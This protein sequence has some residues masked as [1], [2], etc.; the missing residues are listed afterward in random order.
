MAGKWD[1][2]LKRLV[3]ANPQEF[4][5]WLVEGAVFT[6]ELSVE[7]NREIYIDI[8]YETMR[9]GNRELVHIEFQR[10]EDENMAWRALEYNAF[11]TCKYK[12]PVHSFV[13]YLKKEGK[14]A[15]SPLVV[16]S[17]DGH[18]IWRF[19]FT[20][21]KLWEIPTERFRQM[22][23]AGVLPLL[24]LTREG[25]HREVVEEAI[26]GIEQ[27]EMSRERKDTLLTIVFNLATL[28][29]NKQEDLEWLKG[30]FRMYQDIIKDT[31]IYQIIVQEGIEKQKKKEVDDLHHIILFTVQRNFPAL[32]EWT[33]ERIEAIADLDILKKLVM[34]T[35][36]ADSVDQM[37]ALFEALQKN[38]QGH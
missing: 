17:A 20:N 3:E 6:R 22:Q 18:E 11:A 5:G 38:S 25:G 19:N 30:R 36:S 35:I 24:A 29:F 32:A 37:R 21:I 16:K 33:T 23:S 8:L 28:G 1:S 15:E 27:A 2:N 9:D 34:D 26:A 7:M 31:E 4:I 13:I 12:C 14:I 10:Y